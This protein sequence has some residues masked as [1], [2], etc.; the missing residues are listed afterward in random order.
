[1]T[2][3]GCLFVLLQTC[4]LES[5]DGSSKHKLKPSRC[6]LF[7]PFPQSPPVSF[8]ALGRRGFLCKMLCRQQIRFMGPDEGHQ[9]QDLLQRIQIICDINQKPSPLINLSPRYHP[10]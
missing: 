1:M 2:I 9:T 7:L 8:S 3:V 4:E 10:E 6:N 5:S